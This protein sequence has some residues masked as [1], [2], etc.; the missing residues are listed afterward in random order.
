MTLADDD[1]FG[2]DS[3]MASLRFGALTWGRQANS[4]AYQDGQKHADGGEDLR[5]LYMHS[6][7]SLD[8]Y[9]RGYRDMEQATCS[10]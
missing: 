8:A 9:D 1:T 10:G 5:A 4:Q 6:A 2:E 7:P 3:D